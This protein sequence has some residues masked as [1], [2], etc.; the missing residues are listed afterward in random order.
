[1]LSWQR[2]QL[3]IVELCRI[4]GEIGYFTQIQ[5]SDLHDLQGLGEENA[6]PAKTS[7]RFFR[8]QHDL[9]ERTFGHRLTFAS[10]FGPRLAESLKVQREV[11]WRAAFQCD[12]LTGFITVFCRYS[13]HNGIGKKRG[14]VR[15]IQLKSHLGILISQFGKKAIRSIGG[16]LQKAFEVSTL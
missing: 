8:I 4:G 7:D 12:E 3:E 10:Q 9:V 5:S 6:C 15:R 2:A 13:L 14:G 16:D 11:I 1:G